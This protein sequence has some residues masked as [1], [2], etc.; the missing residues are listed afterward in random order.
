[1]GYCIS[2]DG[3]P[4][5][6]GVPYLL[7]WVRVT[8]RLDRGIEGPTDALGHTYISIHTRHTTYTDIYV[9]RFRPIGIMFHF[10]RFELRWL[11]GWRQAGKQFDDN[12]SRHAVELH[13]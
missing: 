10:I 9:I 2:H 8:Q 3:I 1:M 7:Y 12:P 5:P 13:Y 4:Y 11:A 6:Y